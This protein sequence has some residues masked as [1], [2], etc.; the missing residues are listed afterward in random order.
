MAE[1][2]ESRL[3]RIPDHIQTIAGVITAIGII[4]GAFGAIGQW[5]VHEVSASTNSRID[6]L[7][8]KLE[9]E[10]N[11]NKLAIMRVELSNLIQ[12]DP[13]NILETEK[14]AREY[15]QNGG[16][17]YLTGMISAWC[18]EKHVNCGE[19]MLK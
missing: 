16:N 4:C 8:K 10:T 13:D 19:I 11:E 1:K 3:K 2:K 18:E 7:E 15:F 14:Y 12:N 9:N 5:I 17:R 6:A